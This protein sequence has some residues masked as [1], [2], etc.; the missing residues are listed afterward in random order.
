MSEKQDQSAIYK[1]L[2][3]DMR[4]GL[5]DIYQQIATA[6][7]NQPLTDS[8]TD[9]LFHE[10]SDQLDEV[11]KA[12]EEAT[13]NIMEIVERHL[14]IQ[15]KNSDILNT[16]KDSSSM[17]EQ[18]DSLTEHNARL[19]EDLASVLT[20]LS[21]QDITG[22]RIKRV[23]KALNQIEDKVVELYIA[24]GLMLEGAQNTPEK[25]PSQLQTEAHEA[26]ENFRQSRQ[27]ELK[28]PD[29]NGISQTAIDDL[30]SQLGV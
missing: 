29:K 23:V 16:L 22:Q 6:S 18:I 3:T 19:G 14:D 1:Q 20:I 7:K 10:A 9:K 28:G 30:L 17:P 15:A 5:K 12:T 26:V 11:L 21:F 25:D 27:G 2:S 4:E 24:S 8:N 13:M